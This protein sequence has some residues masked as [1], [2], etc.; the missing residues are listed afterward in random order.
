M[1]VRAVLALAAALGWLALL[2]PAGTAAAYPPTT[3]PTIAVSTTA[4]AVGETITVSGSNFDADAT[5]TIQLHSATYDLGTDHT[6]ASGTFSARVTLPAGV[7]G[8]H[9]I[10]VQ[11]AQSAC[12]ADPVQVDIQGTGGP[13]SASVANGSPGS[14]G[15]GTAFTGV[16]IL[17]L[18]VAAA[19]LIGL[20]V[21][22][23]RRSSGRRSKHT[24]VH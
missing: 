8:H 17:G 18:L 20:G 22:L 12:P 16:D 11:G 14:P 2:A 3:C 24:S 9:L 19:A 23:N 6:D 15:T 10:E 7:T 5:V 21:L 13:A 1:K 4:P